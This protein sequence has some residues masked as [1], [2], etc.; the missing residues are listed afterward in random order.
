MVK[1]FMRN[2]YSRPILSLYHYFLLILNYFP[3]LKKRPFD[4]HFLLMKI[5]CKYG[6]KKLNSNL[7]YFVLKIF[8]RLANVFLKS[9]QG[10]RFVPDNFYQSFIR[11]HTLK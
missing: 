10:Q 5:I 9:H 8:N 2:T 4:K 7:H 6:V 11:C 3:K 1:K